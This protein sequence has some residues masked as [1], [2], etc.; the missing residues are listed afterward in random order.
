MLST[1]ECRKILFKVGIKLGVSPKLISERLL[2]DLDKDDML[3]GLISIESLIAFTEVWRD[4]G[5]PDYAHGKFETYEEEKSRESKRF[6]N[7]E[8]NNDTVYRRPFVEY[9]ADE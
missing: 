1:D 2:S 3:Q 6:D 8:K 9:R 4:N 7:V 5:M